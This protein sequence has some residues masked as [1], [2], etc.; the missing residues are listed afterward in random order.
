[1]VLQEEDGN[2]V[3]VFLSRIYGDSFVEEDL[4]AINTRQMQYFLVYK[5][6]SSLSNALILQ[7]VL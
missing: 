5:G 7:L 4:L 2:I 1:V 3:N 6:K